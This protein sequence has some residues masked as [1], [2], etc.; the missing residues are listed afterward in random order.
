MLLLHSV[1][2]HALSFTLFLSLQNVLNYWFPL[3]SPHPRLLCPLREPP[4]EC[5]ETADYAFLFSITSD[6]EMRQ[7]GADWTLYTEEASLK[8][9]SDLLMS[10]TNKLKDCVEV[11]SCQ[12]FPLS[13][14]MSFIWRICMM[15]VTAGCHWSVATPLSA[16]WTC[17]LFALHP[18]T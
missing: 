3:N 8:M 9:R 13:A 14:L 7:K 1:S 5:G 15:G 2:P 4:L 17:F 6:A 18:C 16:P 12:P 11:Q 10:V